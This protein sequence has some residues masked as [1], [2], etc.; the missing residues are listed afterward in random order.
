MSSLW[1]KTGAEWML[2]LKFWV[3]LRRAIKIID[4][5]FMSWIDRL[6]AFPSVCTDMLLEMK[7]EKDKKLWF[8]IGESLTITWFSW[9]LIL[10]CP[11][12]LRILFSSKQFLIQNW[13]SIEITE[14][15]A[16]LVLSLSC[17][18]I[19]CA[20]QFTGVLNLLKFSIKNNRQTTN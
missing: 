19:L 6:I 18:R 13:F 16:L 12:P 3:T 15:G 11:I 17:S 10:V 7:R 4:S 1:S 8:S 14:N 20:K 5:G 2:S 9:I